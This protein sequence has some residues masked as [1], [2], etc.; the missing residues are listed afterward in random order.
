MTIAHPPHPTT[1]P[2]DKFS[3]AELED[4]QRCYDTA[5]AV[6]WTTD[7]SSLY[8]N[9]SGVPCRIVSCTLPRMPVYLHMPHATLLHY[10]AMGYKLARCCTITIGGKHGATYHVQF[11]RDACIPAA[12]VDAK[13]ACEYTQ[14]QQQRVAG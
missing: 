14:Q 9:A 7:L 5:Q 4:A 2:R 8:Y 12:S 6:H 1:S 10:L 3:A 13:L 11:Q